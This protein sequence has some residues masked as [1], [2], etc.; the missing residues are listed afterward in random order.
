[1]CKYCFTTTCHT[2]VITSLWI[3]LWLADKTWTADS[4]N[5][6]AELN[7]NCVIVYRYNRV[8]II[9]CSKIVNYDLKRVLSLFCILLVAK[10]FS[11]GSGCGNIWYFRYLP[12]SKGI[13]ILNLFI[14]SSC[15]V[16]N[17]I[18]NCNL[19]VECCTVI[20]LIF[21]LS[22]SLS[23]S[24]IGDVGTQEPKLFGNVWQIYLRL[25]YIIKVSPRPSNCMV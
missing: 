17:C 8:V 25:R 15:T 23:L 4:V 21:S 13:N 20:V 10:L 19:T 18:Y 6:M 24:L 16:C 3:A 9:K 12:T 2:F 11:I 14:L 1:M 7:Y 5:Q 22:S